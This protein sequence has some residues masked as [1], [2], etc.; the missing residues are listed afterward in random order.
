LY[1]ILVQHDKGLGG[2]IL[3]W[4]ACGIVLWVRAFM[5]VRKEILERAKESKKERI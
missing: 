5:K 1:L 4:L 2:L 3:F